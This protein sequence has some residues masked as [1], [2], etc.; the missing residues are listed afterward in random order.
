[1]SFLKTIFGAMNTRYVVRAYVIGLILAL[2]MVSMIWSLPPVENARVRPMSEQVSLGV[3]FVINLLLF[4]FSKLSWDEMR[5]FA[6]GDTMIVMPVFVLFGA[7]FLVN[8]VLL[9]ASFL[10]APLGILYLWF[11]SKKI[12]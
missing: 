6:L 1:M 2:I 12:A 8:M 11:H 7:K 3:I 9:M 10:I 4:P 5:G